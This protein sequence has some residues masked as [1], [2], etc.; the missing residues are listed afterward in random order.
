[1]DNIKWILSYLK[2]H[3]LK[4]FFALFLV[5]ITSA[6]NMVYP[7]ITGKFVDRVLGKGETSLLIP[8]VSIM[9]SVVVVKGIMTYSYQM[10]LEIISQDVLFKLRE[11]LY[12]KLLN[13]D[14]NFYSRVKTGD[15]MARMTGDTDAIRHFVAWVVYNILSAITTFSFAIISMMY[16]NAILTISMLLVAPIIGF[17]SNNSF[18]FSPCNN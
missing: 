7:F 1:M 8:L 3:R 14:I 2:K 9:I 12:D 15:L 18:I 10:I 11:D 6:I 5:L 16:I 13:L 4:Y 17:S